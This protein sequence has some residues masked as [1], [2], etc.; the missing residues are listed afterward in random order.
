MRHRLAWVTLFAL[1]LALGTTL[2][3][4]VAAR[5][6]TADARY[7]PSTRSARYEAVEALAEQHFPAV[8]AGWVMR[9]ALCESSYDV[10]AH[11]AGF[12]RRLGVR[13]DF[14]G[15]LQVD[16]VTWADKA[17]YLFGGYLS[18]PDVNFAMAAW[19]LY[20]LGPSPWPVCGH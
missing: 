15:A 2:D 1:A 8:R 20:H 11:R 6:Q 5:A 13:Y 10:H 18:E 3:G 7:A 19:I 4:A 17:Y 9:T 12:D 14:W 16:A